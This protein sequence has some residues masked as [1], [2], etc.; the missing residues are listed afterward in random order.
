MHYTQFEWKMFNELDKSDLIRY[1]IPKLTFDDISEKTVIKLTNGLS[2]IEP[3]GD[4][5]TVLHSTF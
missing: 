1:P 2:E 3:F 4:G 5:I